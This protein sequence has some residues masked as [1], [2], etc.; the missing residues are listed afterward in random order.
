MFYINVA[1]FYLAGESALLYPS[2]QFW[3][4]THEIFI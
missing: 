3:Q 4:F 2:E 1:K